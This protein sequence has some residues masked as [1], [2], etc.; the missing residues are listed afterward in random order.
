MNWE[1]IFIAL[2]M[3]A[4]VN[5]FFDLKNLLNPFVFFY[6][7]QTVFCFIALWYCDS[8]YPR[9]SISNDLKTYIILAYILTFVGALISKYLFSY[10]GINYIRMN[11]I[12]IE[13]RPSKV[14]L[15]SGFIVYV[16]GI[17]FFLLFTYKTG[18]IILFADDIENERITRKAG[19][20]LYNL[21]F[22][23]FLG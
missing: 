10:S 16:L 9:I 19:A 2:I 5:K 22:I 4:L 3:L 15:I 8:W 14:F 6:I 21:I 18:G 11:N 7:Y 12:K 17:L 23:S 13:K 20:G 1:I